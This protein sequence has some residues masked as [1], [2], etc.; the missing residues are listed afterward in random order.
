LL[1]K[2]QS[3]GLTKCV[4]APELLLVAPPDT[5]LLTDGQSILVGQLFSSENK[6]LEILPRKFGTCSDAPSL[7]SALESHWGNYALFFASNDRAGAYREPSGSVSVNRCGSR[8]ETYFV[9]DAELAM[10]LGIL[11]RPVP[12]MRF[13]VHWLQFPFLRT[14][15]TGLENIVELLPGMLDI[16][17]GSAPWLE[18]SIW[19]P[20]TFTSPDRAI[21]HIA[22]AV[23]QLRDVA[24]SVIPAQAGSRAIA[25]RLS[26]GLDSSIIA[27]CLA[28]AGLDFSAINFVTRSPDGDERLYARE[29]AARFG[30]TLHEIGEPDGGGLELPAS[31][32][33]RPTIN[34]LL[35]P[36][37]R[38]ARVTAVDLRVSLLLDG[39][40]GDNLFCSIPTASPVLDA[41]QVRGFHQAVGTI[42]DIARRAG[43]TIWEVALAALRRSVR[44]RPQ[45]TEDRSFL[46]A[47]CAVRRELHPWLEPLHA[48]P[49]KR[50]HVEALVHIQHFLD[51]GVSP[52]GLLHPLMA[53]PL[54]ELCLR[55]ASW[56]WM[57]GGRDRAVARQAFTA[58]V[59][60]AVLRRR[61]KGSLQSMFHRAFFRNRD[62]MLDLL[63]SGQ[64]RAAGIVDAVSLEAALRGDGW[65]KE[66][67]QLRISEMVALE[68]W[69]QSWRSLPPYSSDP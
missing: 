14:R 1:I 43:C 37:E 10:Q 47:G 41:L 3:L 4:E 54:L 12:D 57:G 7:R 39:G 65:K 45:W 62:E 11:A 61:T 8:D 17:C 48:G 69:L 13:A 64:L 63:L 23:T 59:P 32:S 53:Q 28:H 67:E 6:R 60:R 42:S 29:V 16:R 2:S 30:A 27:A 33:F 19:H 44:G 40:G 38:A 9:S 35:A 58:I 55:I 51:R 21:M 15:R 49:G 34:P 24:L 66:E 52:I 26:G 5:A 20:Q 31:Y 22:D 68:L 56:L 46:R 25:L 50:E 36:F 18:A